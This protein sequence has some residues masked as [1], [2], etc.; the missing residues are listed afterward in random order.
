[1]NPSACVRG[2]K[3]PR[4]PQLRAPALMDHVALDRLA[5]L[6]DL[7][8]PHSF[9]QQ[10]TRS[11]IMCSGFGDTHVYRKMTDTHIKSKALKVLKSAR[12]S[13]NRTANKH[14]FTATGDVCHGGKE[15]TKAWKVSVG[16]ERCIGAG[17]ERPGRCCVSRTL[18][19]R[20]SNPQPVQRMRQERLTHLR[21]S[22]EPGWQR[23]LGRQWEGRLR[24]LGGVLICS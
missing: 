24:P 6:S 2:S 22:Q 21:K 7:Q 23:E 14:K 19:G 11:L 13:E 5:H 4:A 16:S 12:P 10:Y 3:G 18:T 17:L 8:L 15:K 20:P 9:L 1:M